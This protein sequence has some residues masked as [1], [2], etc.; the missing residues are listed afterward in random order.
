MN[1]FSA[2]ERGVST[3]LGYSLTL[4]ITAVLISGL[5]IAGG[6]LVSDQRDRI[7]DEELSVTVEQLASGLNDADRLAQSTDGGVMQVQ[8]WLPERIAGGAY[9]LELRNESDP[10]GQPARATLTATAQGANAQASL[11]LRTGVPVANRTVIGGPLTVSHR[12]ADDDG[13]RELV[14][15]ESRGLE[16]EA[17][18]VPESAAMS[19][20]ELVFVNGSTHELSS[21]DTNGT[22]TRY[23]VD[24]Q[25][26]G[27]KQVDIDGDGLREI[28]YVDL[29]GSLRIIDS[30]GDQQ[31]LVSDS[32]P[33]SPSENKSLVGIDE[34]NGEFYVLYAT[35]NGDAYRVSLAENATK[36]GANVDGNGISG[37]AG[38]DDLDDDG[39][40]D[41]VSADGSQ[42]LRY[43][44]D[45]AS[46]NEKVTNGGLGASL[47]T[48]FGAPRDFDDDGRERV[49]MIDGSGN[50]RLINADGRTGKLT[51]GA[52]K[53]PLAG[54]EWNSTSA[55]QEIVFVEETTIGGSTVYVLRYIPYTGGPPQTITVD[56]DPVIVD[57]EAGVA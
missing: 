47:G 23:G 10:S 32:S 21:L 25:S 31:L 43:Y 9:T 48:G 57:A 40:A 20:E 41:L 16:P 35:T 2:E 36:I 39:V 1:S 42:Q 3:A 28:P 37:I 8:I 13:Q 34:W 26:I 49:P 38:V 50:V 29:G 27:P 11:S 5:L 17:P 24:A 53:A 15:N 54:I 46:S 56:G 30:E 14:V 33:V 19:H 52:T 22:V 44:E 55:G 51:S 4:G 6:T 7:A 12:D 18:E 45:G